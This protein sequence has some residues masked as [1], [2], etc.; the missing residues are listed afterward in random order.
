MSLQ[1]PDPAPTPRPYT[2]ASLLRVDHAMRRLGQVLGDVVD[3]QDDDV[4]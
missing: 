4:A 2:P 3:H 1:G